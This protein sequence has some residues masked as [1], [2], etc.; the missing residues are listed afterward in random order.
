MFILIGLIIYWIISSMKKDSD[1]FFSVLAADFSGVY[2]VNLDTDVIRH[3]LFLIT[4]KNVLKKV[5]V[6]LV[7]L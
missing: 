4:L 5:M 3:L 2:F 7:R 6:S 1:A